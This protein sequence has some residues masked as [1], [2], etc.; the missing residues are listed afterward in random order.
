VAA[1][2]NGLTHRLSLSLSP[3]RML[4]TPTASASALGAGQHEVAVPLIVPPCVPF[5]VDPSGLGHA[6]TI[7]SSVQGP[8]GV[9]TPTLL[10]EE[11]NFAEVDTF[12]PSLGF[13]D[14]HQAAR[15][16]PLTNGHPRR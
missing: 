14:F 1:R 12:Q 9:E 15:L 3:S 6:A 10:L 13:K 8:P 11:C 7:Y 16:H 5:R 2:E 4:V